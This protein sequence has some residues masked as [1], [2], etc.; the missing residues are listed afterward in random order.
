MDEREINWKNPA[1]VLRQMIIDAGGEIDER[2]DEIL[3]ELRDYCEE[4][5]SAIAGKYCINGAVLPAQLLNDDEGCSWSPV[6]I[7]GTG[8]S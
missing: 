2:G 6:Y 1:D 3:T 5:V 8:Y 7:S 4:K